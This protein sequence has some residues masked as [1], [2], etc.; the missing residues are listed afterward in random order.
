MKKGYILIGW[1]CGMFFGLCGCFHESELVP[2]QTDQDWYVLEDSDD[3]LDHL[4]YLIFEQYGVPVYYK[5]TIGSRTDGTDVYGNP[6]IYYEVLDPDYNLVRTENEYEIYRSRDREKLI[7]AVEFMK[8]EV[9][10]LFC[11]RELLPRCFLLVDSVVHVARAA[12]YVTH[13]MNVY[14]SMMTSVVGKVWYLDEIS[15]D[16]RKRF[17]A[18]IVAEEWAAYLVQFQVGKLKA[19]YTISESEVY[20]KSTTYEKSPMTGTNPAKGI[21]Y[22][23]FPEYGFLD[24]DHYNKYNEGTEYT[25]VDK[26]ADVVDYVTE[27]LLDDEEG[28]KTKYKSYKWVL[29]KY[30][31]MKGIVESVTAE[32]KVT[33]DGK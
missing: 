23:I 15:G 8:D 12:Q 19:F 25:T 31:L 5:D 27:I 21:P 22:K 14:R 18:E 6:V 13:E 16:D 30:E 33:S 26:R 10:P 7:E 11:S 9:L 29:Q 17:I 4:R 28:F 3:E 20:S 1:L 32:L 2:T 24:Y